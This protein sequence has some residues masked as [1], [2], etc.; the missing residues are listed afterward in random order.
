[1]RPW[2]ETWLSQGQAP[3]AVVL[4]AMLMLAAP[5]ASRAGDQP[6]DPDTEQAIDTTLKIAQTALKG[7]VDINDEERLLLKDMMV[8]SLNGQTAEACGKKVLLTQLQKA[9]GLAPEEAKVVQPLASCLLDGG[10]VPTCAQKAIVAQIDDPNARKM[11]DCVTSGAIGAA[12]GQGAGAATD[13]M[14]QAVVDIVQ[15]QDES[16]GAITDCLLKGRPVA[17]CGA[18]ALTTQLGPQAGPIAKCLIQSQSADPTQLISK[19]AP[20][21][22]GSLPPELKCFADKSTVQSC[23]QEQIVNQLPGD[24]RE[25]A[26]CVLSPSAAQQCAKD[27][28]KEQLGPLADTADCIASNP[29]PATCGASAVQGGLGGALDML[30]KMMQP[31]E[32][33]SPGKTPSA[34]ANFVKVADGIRHD[35]WG[36]V[37]EYGGAEIGKAAAKIVF[38]VFADG[39]TGPLGELLNQLAGPIIDTMV[40]DRI[41]L[42]NSLMKELRQCKKGHC[43]EAKIGEILGEFYMLL[44][45]EVPCAILGAISEKFRQV[46]CGPVG[47]AIVTIGSAG[48]EFYKDNDKAI[49]GVASVLIPGEGPFIAAAILAT[50]PDVQHAIT[51]QEG[52]CPANYFSEKMAVCLKRSAFL[53]FA[54]QAGANKFRQD[55]EGACHAAFGPCS[56]RRIKIGGTDSE[57]ISEK[58]DPL[59]SAYDKT[60]DAFKA[61][62]ADVANQYAAVGF[63]QSIDICAPDFVVDEAVEQFAKQ[64]AGALPAKLPGL[65]GGNWASCDFPDPNPD[66]LLAACR[67]AGQ[68]KA[69]QQHADFVRTSLHGNEGEIQ[70]YCAK[71]KTCEAYAVNAQR[72]ANDNITETCGGVGPRWTTSFEEHR[73]WCLTATDAAAQGEEQARQDFLLTCR[74]CAEYA[75]K[76]VGAART[77]IKYN[78]GGQPPRF[79]LDRADHI[80]FC[81]SA[82]ISER[83]SEEDARSIFLQP[84]LADWRKAHTTPETATPPP[85][86][87]G[88]MVPL[89]SGGCD[90][91]PHTYFDGR[92][93]VGDGTSEATKPPSPAAPPPPVTT[94]SSPAPAPATSQLVIA[95]RATVASCTDAGGGCLFDIVVSN[96]G[97]TPFAGPVEVVET[98]KTDGTPAI[99]TNLRADPPKPWKCAKI[100]QAQFLCKHPGPVPPGSSVTLSVNFGLRAGTGAKVMQN[101]AQ[102]KGSGEPSCASIALIAQAAPAAPATPPATQPAATHNPKPRPCPQGQFWNGHACAPTQ[103]QGGTPQSKQGEQSP[104]EP[105][106]QR[107]PQS[108]VCFSCSHND[109][110]ENGKCVPCRAGFHVEGEDCVPD[111][112]AQPT[113][114]QPNDVLTKTCPDGSTVPVWKKCRH[115]QQDND[116]GG[117]NGTQPQECAPGEISVNGECRA[118]GMPGKVAC[119]EGQVSNNGV[120]VPATCPDGMTGK[121]PACT[122]ECP[123]GYRV[124]DKPNKY[125]AYCEEIPVPGPAPTPEPEPEKTGPAPHKV[126]NADKGEVLGPSGDC[127]CPEGMQRFGSP[128]GPCVN[129]TN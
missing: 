98:L 13:C 51:G 125:G 5:G 101:C 112:G 92:Q 107:D 40:A 121:P 2:R 114:E 49:A 53:S 104:C 58:C 81:Q 28:L 4:L 61:G 44:Q 65:D 127:V 84:C 97:T 109:H 23:I 9:A 94:P 46:T 69:R 99:S 27:K 111:A 124:L 89:E 60:L 78:C 77:N 70:A 118:G 80:R 11:V 33:V 113:E 76:A 72:D 105:G 64:C 54:D 7:T 123:A 120:C 117:T 90:C 56:K 38:H 91:P 75:D 116:G 126:C 1:M 19:C 10:T 34:L 22:L 26:K 128:D 73:K 47:E 85:R 29:N 18:D 93:C 36:E 25:V 83:R 43:D 41:E 14:R 17:E 42:F 119:P 50:D 102:I 24:Q 68:S 31:A 55:I 39:L 59:M 62:I 74:A 67:A 86:C 35:D 48:Y 63:K 95:K 3:F 20:S 82:S 8:C 30:G 57:R 6:I 106:Q 87:R 21:G 16:L 71:R 88:G 52:E 15:K 108:G 110:F 103:G 12:Q 96:T 100:D 115:H 32:M 79:S 129:P 122:R 37:F 45:V 66:T